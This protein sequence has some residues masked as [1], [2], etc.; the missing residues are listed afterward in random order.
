[1]MLVKPAMPE[2]CRDELR[3]FV[4]ELVQREVRNLPPGVAC[5]RRELCEALL[6]ANRETGARAAMREAAAEAIRDWKAQGEQIAAL[7]KLGFT[8]TKGK[9][10]YK[11]RWGDSGYFKALSASPSDYRT[12]ANGV[13]EMQGIFF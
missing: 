5:R 1:M 13:A 11:M 3:D 9:K 8:V 10:H 7:E 12:G 2:M 6:A 4:L